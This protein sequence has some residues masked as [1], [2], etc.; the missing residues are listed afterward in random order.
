MDARVR[1]LLAGD[2]SLLVA[3][4]IATFNAAPWHD[5][6]QSET[7]HA[8][9]AGLCAHPE[10]RAWVIERDD[11]LLG[12]AF[13]HIRRWWAGDELFVDEFFVRADCQRQG[14]G[15]LLLDTLEAELRAEGVGAVT[16]LTA[17]A[18]PAEDFYLAQDY[19]GKPEL[20]FM[21]KPLR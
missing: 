11:E 16:L 15:R 14:L 17:R 21:V 5:E 6:W 4:F 20:R 12:A 10:A 2:L 9:L 8:Y 13:G 18:T 1:P 3:G 19:H 7:A